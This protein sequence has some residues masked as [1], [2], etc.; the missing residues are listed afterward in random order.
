MRKLINKTIGT[1]T[2]NELN[3]VFSSMANQV[4]CYGLTQDDEI[5]FYFEFKKS[6]VSAVRIELNF[7]TKEKV[8]LITLFRLIKDMSNAP[9]FDNEDT[10]ESFIDPN[11]NYLIFNEIYQIE[12]DK[13]SEI[14][15][16]DL[17]FDVRRKKIDVK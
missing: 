10:S 14:S 5:D 17:L 16:C 9:C 15:D 11:G 13:V 1:P 7:N 12:N 4:R 8:V 6:I 2:E 3:K